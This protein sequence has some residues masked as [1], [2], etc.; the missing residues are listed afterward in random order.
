MTHKYDNLFKNASKTFYNSTRL[1]PK[2]IR[3]DVFILYAFVRTVDD[4]VDGDPQDIEGFNKFWNKYKND[5]KTGSSNS[6]LINDFIKLSDKYNFDEEWTTAFFESM[7]SDID[8]VS[9]HRE[10]DTLKYIF[11][12]ASVIGLYMAKILNLPEASYKYAAGM[13]NAFQYI[14]FIRDVKEDLVLER[15][16]FPKVDL[17]SFKIEEYNKDYFIKYQDRFVKFLKYQLEKYKCWMVDSKDGLKYIPK[18]Y[19]VAIKTAI[20]LYNWT[21]R[22]IERDPMIVLE[23]KVKP[24]KLVITYFAFKNLILG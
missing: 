14:N 21:G 15:N 11:G 12:S 19:R 2:S 22:V 7:Q 23:K 16:Y 4:F 18:R 8:R 3:D 6:E 13:G 10:K 1:F 5:R 9:Y 20:D 24:S 17:K